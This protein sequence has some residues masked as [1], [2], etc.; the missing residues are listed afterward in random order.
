MRQ[1]DL[2]RLM[3]VCLIWAIN[4]V[5]GKL[6]LSGMAVPPFYYAGIRFL[7]VA[8]LLSRLLLP[9][10]RQIVR[11][12][13]AGLLMGAGHFGFL[14]LGLASSSPS[15]ASIVLQFG[16]PIT[17]LLS[18]LFLGERLSPRRIGGIA[19]A[20]AGVIIVIWDPH[21]VRLSTGLI[22]VLIATVS[23][24][25]G[26]ILM[27]RMEPIPS[28]RLQAWVALVSFGP[29]GVASALLEH[30][31]IA[32]TIAG[33]WPLA[34]AILFSAFVVTGWAHTA[35]YDLLQRYEA[36]VV[37]PLTLTMPIMTMAL[38]VVFTH[39]RIDLRM[40]VGAVLAVGGIWVLIGP[41]RRVRASGVSP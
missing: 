41:R 40:V 1:R 12:V 13:I 14:F 29:L 11:V 16:I 22:A 25:S 38:G 21:G 18:F 15:A 34:I 26:A 36:N 31:Q 7:L 24:A 28:L 2:L 8:T 37:V 6:V 10:P 27:K 35:Y 3:L 39:D 19:V 20:L 9:V 30:N 23:L 5:A 17:T 4:V 33:G 32:L